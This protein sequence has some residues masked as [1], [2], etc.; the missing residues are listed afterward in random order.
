MLIQTV[1]NNLIVSNCFVIAPDRGTKALVVDPGHGARH[2]VPKL[3]ERFDL[4]LGEILLTHGHFDHVWDAGQFGD[5]PVWIPA[6]DV[7]RLE[8]P[9]HTTF[10]PNATAMM[11]A[12]GI[13]FWERWEKP[14]DIRPLPEAATTTGI[15]LCGIDIRVLPAPGHTAGSALYL[16]GGTF[17][18]ETIELPANAPIALSGDVIFAG[19]VG[20]TDLPGG[21]HREMMQSLRLIQNVIDPATVL[22]P[23]HGDA[24]TL[25]YEKLHNPYLKQA[26]KQG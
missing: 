11:A 22:L 17:T 2:K 21:D 16:L 18:S 25:E 3:L 8:D 13:E 10:G 23:G 19:S 4:E 6:P 9:L 24:T 14:S 15:N 26:A 5:V 7:P 12:S 1:P 20:R